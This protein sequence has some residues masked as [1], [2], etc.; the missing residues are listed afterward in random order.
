MNDHSVAYYNQFYKERSWQYN[1]DAERKLLEDNVLPFL[2]IRPGDK[3]LDLGCGDGFH[4]KVLFDLGFS[5]FGV[6]NSEEGIARAGRTHE[7]PKFLC[8][9]AG[10]MNHLFDQQFFDCIFCRGL[11]W[12]HYELNS[13]NQ[14]GIDVQLE[15]QKILRYLKKDGRF[16]LQIATDFSG[17][18]D[19]VSGV[20]YNTLEAYLSFFSQ[21]GKIRHVADWKG[22]PVHTGTAGDAQQFGISIVI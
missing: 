6:D 7:G 5:V 3:V 18:R 2:E 8:A 17:R 12:Y 1:Y 4:S 9:N 21:F 22:N 19:P 13:N 14:F 16:L 10:D 20:I 15:T 11:S